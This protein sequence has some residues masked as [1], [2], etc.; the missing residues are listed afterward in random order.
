MKPIC[1]SSAR[2]W[3]TSGLLLVWSVTV[4]DIL[5][6][7]A[8]AEWYIGGYG[9]IANPGAFSNVTASG[10]TLGGGVSEV[11][12]NDLEL[13]STL[14]GGAKVGYFFDKAPWLG[15]ETDVYTLKP[16]VKGQTVLGGTS[17]GR[18]FADYIGPI[19][20]QLTTLAVDIIIRSPSISEVFQPYGGMGYG[21]FFA[22]SSQDGISNTQISPGFNLIA[23][24][25][26][27]LSPRWAFFG[28]FKFNRATIRFSDIRGNYDSQLFVFGFMWDDRDKY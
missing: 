10:S 12:L 7:T 11:R 19:P 28:E 14:V 26:Y 8:Q 3:I 20:L 23:G 27:A 18:V 4:S 22:T 5:T 21:L 15:L 2:P 9:G 24:A 16:T 13:K 1:L 17:S 25:R 6:P